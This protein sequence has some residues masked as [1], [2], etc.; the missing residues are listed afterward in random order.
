MSSV[1]DPNCHRPHHRGYGKEGVINPDGMLAEKPTRG[2]QCGKNRHYH[3]VNGTSKACHH[4]YSIYFGNLLGHSTII[5]Y[6]L[7][8]LNELQ[9]QKC[10]VLS[11]WA[12]LLTLG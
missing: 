10:P 6:F 8:K 12:R 1:A 4:T 3:A 5:A 11:Y 9:V 7:Q 2:Q